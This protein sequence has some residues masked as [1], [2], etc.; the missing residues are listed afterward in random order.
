MY[1]VIFLIIIYFMTHHFHLFSFDFM[2]EFLVKL[3]SR[4]V[5][6]AV[7]NKNATISEIAPTSLVPI[8]ASFRVIIYPCRISDKCRGADRPKSPSEPLMSEVL[9]RL[10]EVILVPVHATVYFGVETA[11]FDAF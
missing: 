10:F 3:P 6:R 11:F 2:F 7:M 4:F 5:V 1:L 9:L 8:L